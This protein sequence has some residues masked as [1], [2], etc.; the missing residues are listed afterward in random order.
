MSCL[1]TQITQERE[2]NIKLLSSMK[3]MVAV[4]VGLLLFLI[5]AASAAVEA[6]FDFENDFG[7]LLSKPNSLSG[8]KCCDEC[9]CT[10]SIP[11]QCQCYDWKETCYE[12]CKS[13][14]CLRIW[15]PRCRCFD[16]TDFCYPPCSSSSKVA[17]LPNQN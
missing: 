15:P 13:C 7:L 11:P 16:V 10:K 4:K 5:A 8:K 12:G 3:S 17:E 6:R 2:I 1:F 14:I 9:G